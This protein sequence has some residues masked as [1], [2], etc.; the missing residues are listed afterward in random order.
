MLE[1]NKIYNID[2]LEGIKQIDL[3]S[4]KFIIITDP[5]FN[6]GYHYNEYSDKKEENE[7]FQW[8]S[9]IIGDLPF[10]MIH[11]PESLYKVAKYTNK[12]PERVVSW[13][14]NSNTKRQHRDIA[15]FGIKPDFSKVKQPYKNLNDKRI[16][17]R[18]ELG[19]EGTDLYD[20]WQV[21][22]VKNVSDEKTEHPCQMPIEVMENII[23]IIPDD[24]VIIEPFSG[25][26]TTVE[27]CI[28]NGR[29]YIAFEID[30]YYY[31]LS[32]ERV[33]GINRKGQTSIF[34]DFNR[35]I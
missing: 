29:K 7:Y 2:C 8:L 28:R 1:I 18:I 15:F 19:S 20:W 9:N 32:L 14:Y 3:T 10:V 4:N 26:G 22:Q 23:K 25:S 31:D 33:N 34:T 12:F 35:V 17:E 11:Y 5:P 16:L 21:N 13:V 24:Y 27:A 30:K 6:V